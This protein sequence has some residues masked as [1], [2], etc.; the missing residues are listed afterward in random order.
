M[1][2]INNDVNI[3]LKT[4]TRISLSNIHNFA[5]ISSNSNKEL[6]IYNDDNN[7]PFKKGFKD[8]YTNI[9][10]DLNSDNDEGKTYITTNTEDDVFINCA[11]QTSVPWFTAN[12]SHTTCEIVPNIQYDTGRITI[13]KIKDK[14]V[15]T[16]VLVNKSKG[17]SCAY[18]S[19]V[20]KSYCEN[21]WYDWI[22]T[23]NYYLGNTYYKDNSH[24]TE[25]DVYKCYKPCPDDTLPYTKE[26]GEIKCIP[27]KY[28]GNGIFNK[29]YMYNSLG[30]INL[31]GNLA[32]TDTDKLKYN[33]N[34]LYI[35]HRLIYEYSIENKVDFN[36]YKSDDNIYKL[37]T[38]NSIVSGTKQQAFN[39]IKP[40]YDD[41]YNEL[42]KAVNDNILKNFDSSANKDYN[43]INEFTYAH[44]KF[45]ENE[46]DMYSFTGMEANGLMTDPILIHTWMLVQI[47]KPL[48]PDTIFEYTDSTYGTNPETQKTK[49]EAI[50]NESI[51]KKLLTVFNNYNKEN[52]DNINK[53]KAI[54][55]KNIFF[56]AIN[57]CYNNKTN[58]SVNLIARTKK[59][60]QNIKLLSIIKEDTNNLYY[61][62]SNNIIFNTLSTDTSVLLT[63]LSSITLPHTYDTLLDSDI[64]IIEYKFYKD[65]DIQTIKDKFTTDPA[66]ANKTLRNTYLENGY[67]CHYL[68]SA[69][70]L[71]SRTCPKGYIYN[72]TIK[73]CELAPRI[74]INTNVNTDED[75]DGFKIPNLKNIFTIFIQI[76]VVIL[77]LYIL[78]IL[79][80]MF[81]EIIKKA[82][83]FVYVYFFKT[84]YNI[85]NVIFITGENEYEKEENLLERNVK[86]INS[87]LKTIQNKKELI[88]DYRM[89]HSS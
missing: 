61:Y 44:Y 6:Y 43:I 40:E 66:A 4:L 74:S 51:Y 11:I 12:E 88:S 30:L 49:I 81:G 39:V 82:L 33:T 53:H 71:E 46:S 84:L 56:K 68:F 75:D 7:N 28:F 67:Y 31:I 86:L 57:N 10:T 8:T 42:L 50:Q 24:Y 45:N 21:K 59:A 3:D 27:K 20:N 5:V 2:C 48:D 78:Y 38:L 64:N 25:L 69:E 29:K 70:E 63:P 13:N 9:Q 41:I 36:I 83:N 14:S 80:D 72:T 54:R 1:S 26:N 16:P 65:T 37:L 85:N 62:S 73:E 18:Y 52:K 77:I 22:I 79:H 35:L 89:Q 32:C 17:G 47:F 58:F 23:P 87:E 76:L 55:V 60:L 34:Y 15:I 19:N